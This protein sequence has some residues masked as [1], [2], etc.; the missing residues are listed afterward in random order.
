MKK[1]LIMLADLPLKD[2]GYC[3]N[4]DYF[5]EVEISCIFVFL[6]VL[7]KGQGK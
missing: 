3:V 4:S 2:L 5:Q 6:K 7:R 1:K